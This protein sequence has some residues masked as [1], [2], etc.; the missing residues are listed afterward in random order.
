MQSVLHAVQ[1]PTTPTTP[2][3]M[4]GTVMLRKQAGNWTVLKGGAQRTGF[5]QGCLT[6]HD[7]TLSQFNTSHMSTQHDSSVATLEMLK[8]CGQYDGGGGYGVE[9]KEV[10]LDGGMCVCVCTAFL[11]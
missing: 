6:D 2:E 11:L 3:G 8:N 4:T 9:I 5:L 1:S 10:K 7:E